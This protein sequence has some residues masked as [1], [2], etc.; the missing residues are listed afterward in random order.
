MKKTV[1]IV[2]ALML[3]ISMVVCAVADVMSVAEMSEFYQDLLNR[4]EGCYNYGDGGLIDFNNEHICISP[5]GQVY[6][7]DNFDGEYLEILFGFGNSMKFMSKGNILRRI[8]VRTNN[9]EIEQC[10]EHISD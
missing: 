2:V 7:F 10:L 5:T 4:Y 3:V 9:G 1:A 6:Y 8:Y